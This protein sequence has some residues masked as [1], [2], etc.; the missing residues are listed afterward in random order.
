MIRGD[1]TSR[2]ELRRSAQ[3][4]LDITPSM[5]LFLLVLACL[6]TG[7]LYVTG[8]EG[9][10]DWL[11]RRLVLVDPNDQQSRLRRRFVGA[12]VPLSDAARGRLAVEAA[13]FY[14]EFVPLL[15]QPA[16]GHEIDTQ[17]SADAFVD[18]VFADI[19][20]IEG[21]LTGSPLRDTY[22]EYRSEGELRLGTALVLP[23]AAYATCYAMRLSPIW[24]VVL[25]WLAVA[26]AI[27]LASYG[28]Y[29]YR[30]AHSFAAH[31]IAD[32]VLLAPCMETLK[33]TSPRAAGSPPVNM[34]E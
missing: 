22:D 17:P 11:H 16:R 1:S 7:S 13:R 14:R 21:K 20:W 23:L 4:I 5:P 33:R 8:L 26:I 12:L 25:V 18:R 27:K 29:Y 34:I 3:N 28:L 32:G 9:V 30:R 31:H 10:V 2:L 19:L 6:L 15:P 24:A